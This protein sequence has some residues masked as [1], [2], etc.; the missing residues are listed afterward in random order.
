MYAPTHHLADIFLL[1]LYLPLLQT[2]NNECAMDHPQTPISSPLLRLP[3]EL[4]LE[5]YTYILASPSPLSVIC[6][7]RYTPFSLTTRLLHHPRR[8]LALLSVCRLFYRETRLL[9]FRVNVFGFK[10]SDAFTPW[11]SRFSEQQVNSV[12]SVELV[13]WAGR[14]MVE[15]EA[16]VPKRVE[17]CFPVERLGGLREVGVEVRHNGRVG[18]CKCD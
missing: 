10:S 2:N 14:H 17:E 13:T 11:F 6:W 1:P 7:R 4:R 18:E 12:R 15:G 8:F 3:P 9:P 16:W 5:I